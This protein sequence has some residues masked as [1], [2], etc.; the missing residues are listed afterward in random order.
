MNNVYH[1]IS[2]GLG[3]AGVALAMS[4]R[5]DAAEADVPRPAYSRKATWAG[6]MVAASGAYVEFNRRL[7]DLDNQLGLNSVRMDDWHRLRR[8]AKSEPL[9]APAGAAAMTTVYPPETMRRMQD[10][11]WEGIKRHWYERAPRRDADRD[12]LTF[13]NPPTTDR[14]YAVFVFRYIETPAP[15][16]LAFWH[17][18]QAGSRV[19]LNGEP[20]TPALPPSATSDGVAGRQKTVLR[21]NKGTNLLV[22]KLAPLRNGTRLFASF[23]PALDEKCCER[24]AEE[25]RKSLM[26]DF[27]A[28]MMSFV[29]IHG[30]DFAAWLA[31]PD[32]AAFAARL[33]ARLSGATEEPYAGFLRELDAPGLLAGPEAMAGVLGRF[34]ELVRQVE[35]RNRRGLPPIAFVKR[36]NYGLG[37]TNATMFSHRTGRGSV[38]CVFDPNDP[39][40]GHRVLLETKEGF[41]WDLSPSYDGARL[42]MSCKE[43]NDEPFSVWEI[44]ADGNGLRRL[45]DGKF[46]DFNPVYYP[47]GRIVFCSSRVESFSLCQDFLACALHIMDGDGSNLRRIDFTTLCSNAPAVLPDG[48]IVC[49]RWEY[50][51]KNI[52]SWQG[53]WSINPDGRQLKLYYGNTITI[54]NSRY[55]AKPVPGT[56]RVLITMAGHHQPPVGDIALV[57]RSLGIENAAA[58]TQLTR[59]TSYEVAQGRDWQDRNW[60]PGD[61]LFPEACADPMPIDGK[62]FL[63]SYAGDRDAIRHRVCVLD[64]YGIGGVLIEDE[65]LSCFSAVPLAAREK[66]PVIVGGSPTE[67]GEGTFFVQDIYRGLL[68]QGVRRGQV[69]ELRVVR[70]LP[71]KWNTEGPRYHDHYPIVGHGSYYVKENLGSVPVRDD[72]SAYFHA[73]SNCE[74]YFIA[75]DKDG[76]EVQRM[77]SVTQITTGEEVG[78]AGC[79]D[80]RQAAPVLHAGK[81]S[82]WQLTPDTI[83]PPPW[84]A[85]PFDYVRHVQPVLDRYC[86]KCHEGR[87]PAANL[88]LSGDKTRFFNMSYES[89]VLRNWVE[90]Y[91]INPGPTGVFPALKTGSTVSKLTSL[92]ESGHGGR[93]AMDDESRRR[94]YA[95]IDSN[96]QYYATWDMS[97]PHTM[98]GRDAWMFCEGN[99]RVPPRPEPWMERLQSAFERSGCLACHRQIAD[100]GSGIAGLNQEYNTKINLTRPEY[101]RLL[102]A[103]LSRQAGG[104]GVTGRR[105]GLDAPVMTGTDDPRY[106]ALLEPVAAGKAALEA[107]PRMDMPGGK[108]VPQ[109]REFGKVF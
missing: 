73:P 28:A 24:V 21:L 95:W 33:K 108:A 56:G 101:S 63:V 99:R 107:R 40:K 22:I 62:R 64:Y 14:E 76:R 1:R 36:A 27:P 77:G 52:F 67:R 84:G 46:H 4:F 37:G 47:D 34:E 68:E 75:L 10:F 20:V 18:S 19:F 105:H 72:G 3:L 42:L 80:N 35:A 93:V 78:C 2:I 25:L 17:S 30:H 23:R 61:I 44:G 54:P 71:K 48:S 100:D 50:Q 81:A 57:D 13:P 59:A 5:G 98:G 94:I 7:S 79:H 15:R 97:R 91:F 69:K 88:D 109:E 32:A 92:I 16:E 90:H 55:G 65:K 74:L 89:L 39:A 49:T 96:V 51:D 6:T 11:E 12:A 86:A 83:R 31:Q 38:V 104:L 26:R 60:P 58:M 53:L 87:A 45:T 43:K 8:L 82:R 66:P 70:V 103:H 9:M 106:R 41:V 102:N 85:G 29:N